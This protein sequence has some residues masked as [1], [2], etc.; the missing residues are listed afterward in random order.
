[1]TLYHGSK[2]ADRAKSLRETGFASTRENNPVS[3]GQVELNANIVS[4]G[5]DLNL[6][7]KSNSFGA[8]NP[9]RFVAVE[10]PYADYVFSR[11]N[12]PQTAYSEKNLNVIAR[13]ISGA[14]KHVRPLGLP[15][16]GL[17]EAE[18]SIVDFEKLTRSSGK[19]TLPDDELT[20][21]VDA[22]TESIKRTEDKKQSL[23]KS[24]ALYREKKDIVTANVAYRNIR[25]LTKMLL[26]GSTATKEA[27]GDAPKNVVAMTSTK[28]GIGA[29]FDVEI[30]N[31]PIGVTTIRD[32]AA[33]LRKGGSK[34]RADLLDKIADNIKIIDDYMG[35]RTVKE[36]N[37]ARQSLM[38]DIPKL[39]K[40]GLVSRRS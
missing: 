6:H 29:R 9:E 28:A 8:K 30:S 15:R 12:M 17:Y 40:G 33:T 24:I 31:M 18:D 25:D 37:K 3:A 16:D 10:I 38:N 14:P 20:K 39:N 4:F 36:K 32:V 35:E 11:V 34:E 26:S 5:K 21:K 13:A 27:K 7:F 23:N 2:N 1:V 19:L 22:Y